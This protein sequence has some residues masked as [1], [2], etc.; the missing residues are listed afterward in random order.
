MGMNAKWIKQRQTFSFKAPTAR[1]V[2]LAGDFTQ[3]QKQPIPLHK[4]A[5]G[6]WKA[7]AFLPPGTYQYRYLVDGQW[8]N[9]PECKVHAPNPFGSKNDVVEMY[10]APVNKI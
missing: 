2:L 1:T 5:T 10:P 9:D 4:E 7:N 8:R 6:V 3:W